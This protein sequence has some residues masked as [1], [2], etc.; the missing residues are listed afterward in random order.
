M[1]FEVIVEQIECE[2]GVYFFMLFD[3]FEFEFFV[4]VSIGQVYCVVVDDGCFV[5]VKVQYFGV[6]ELCDSDFNQFKFM[7]KMSGFINTCSYKKVFDVF[8]EEV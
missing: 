2:F 7:F 4:V 8:F 5:I 1:F 6:D 3:F